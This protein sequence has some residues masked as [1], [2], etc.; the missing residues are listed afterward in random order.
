[1]PSVTNVPPQQLSHVHGYLKQEVLDGATGVIVVTIDSLGNL[2]LTT[3][4][5]VQDDHRAA[6]A[7]AINAG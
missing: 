2:R 5:T 1:M 7:T 3:A 4:G 6:A